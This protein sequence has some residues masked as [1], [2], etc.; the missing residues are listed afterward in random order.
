ME[1]ETNRHLLLSPPLAKVAAEFSLS[2]NTFNF[3]F[4][5]CA[6]GYVL[7]QGFQTRL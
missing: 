6:V 7:K 2:G 5:F 1:E 4:A 3:S